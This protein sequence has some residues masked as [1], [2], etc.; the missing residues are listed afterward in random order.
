M[1]MTELWTGMWKKKIGMK[2]ENYRKRND[3]R[4]IAKR[5]PA[6]NLLWFAF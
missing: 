5:Y 1:N 2:L 6:N 3:D 4:I